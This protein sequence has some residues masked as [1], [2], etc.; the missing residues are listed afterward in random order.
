MLSLDEIARRCVT[1]N[2]EISINWDAL[3]PK[4][5][6]F[7]G[8]FREYRQ[9]LDL[10]LYHLSQLRILVPENTP[11][12]YFAINGREQVHPTISQ[13]GERYNFTEQV[14][15]ITYYQHYN[16]DKKLMLAQVLE[17]I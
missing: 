12:S 13:T 6:E 15:A 1:H 5:E 10:L 2:G 17:Q 9:A 7:Q 3:N 16:P 8:D 11:Q 14:H 4:S